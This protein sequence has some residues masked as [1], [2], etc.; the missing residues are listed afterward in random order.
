MA[1]LMNSKT[2]GISIAA[3]PEDVYDFASNPQNLPRWAPAFAKSVAWSDGAW[4]VESPDG[5]I[6]LRFAKPNHFGVLD[7]TVRLPAGQE[8]CNPMRVI[9]NGAGSE[10]IFTLFHAPD[11]PA[12][13][14]A[15][16]IK[17]VESDLRTLKRIMEERAA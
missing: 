4:I 17:L 8:I 12:E 13:K 3:L 11:V 2:I 6:G 14:R 9:P 16:D 15:E 1:Q 10:V 5:P 7:H